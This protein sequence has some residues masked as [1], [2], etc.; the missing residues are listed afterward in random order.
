[1]LQVYTIKSN[2][3][4]FLEIQLRADDPHVGSVISA[5]KNLRKYEL[6]SNK[7]MRA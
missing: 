3:L 2:F 1:M 4:T 6:L 5:T 7:L